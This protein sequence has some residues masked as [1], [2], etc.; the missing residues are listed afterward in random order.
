MRDTKLQAIEL[1]MAQLR[2]PWTSQTIQVITTVLFS[3]PQEPEKLSFVKSNGFLE[4]T[5]ASALAAARMFGGASS[6]RRTDNAHERL[7][8]S[9]ACRMVYFPPRWLVSRACQFAC[10]VFEL[11]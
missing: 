9:T 1:R 2:V 6:K 3:S 4:P 7:W 10:K 8:L 11:K 5:S